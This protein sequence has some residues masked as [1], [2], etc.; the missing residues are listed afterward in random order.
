MAVSD[1]ALHY[2]Q[3]STYDTAATL[4]RSFEAQVDE[5]KREQQYLESV[6]FRA[7]L[8]TVRSDRVATVN[9]GGKGSVQ[10]DVLNKGMGLLLRELFGTSTAPTLVGPALA[11]Q[12]THS[13]TKDG[14]LTSATIQ[15]IRP[16]ADGSTDEFTHLGCVATGWE[17]TGEVDKFLVLKGEYDFQD[18]VT[19]VAAGAATYPANASAHHWAEGKVTVGGTDL[20][21]KKLSL[22]A[23]YK[24]KTDRRFLRQN[25]LKKQP[26]VADV[27][28]Y[29]G[30]LEGEFLSLAEYTRFVNG[31]V[32][33]AVFLFEG[34]IIETSHKFTFKVDMPAI[35]YRGESPEVSLNDLPKQML[36]FRVLHDGTNPAIT[37][38]VKSTDT[39]F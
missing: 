1:A 37:V 9:L 12:Q 26:R 16:F 38:T 18:V 31:T 8:Q 23:D 33:A 15:L 24:P 2:G 17:L 7:G 22:K 36:P 5:W 3:E 32:M 29:T 21:M 35:Q 27:P 20:D 25:P 14:P 11:F 28:E 30:Q 19:N 6:G 39:V 10:L 13:T 4:T 34:A